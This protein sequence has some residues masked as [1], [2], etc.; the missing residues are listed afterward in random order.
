MTVPDWMGSR[1]FDILARAPAGATKD[2]VPQ[3]WQSLLADRFQLAVHREPKTV[4]HY[5]LTV[6]KG[7]PKFTE[8]VEQPV[9]PQGDTGG[10]KVDKDGF[11]ELNRPGMIGAADGRISLYRPNATMDL[12]ARLLAGQLGSPVTDETGLKGSYDIRLHWVR[13]TAPENMGPRLAEAVPQQLGL[14]L[15]WKK[16]PVE[17]LVV[18][19]IEKMPSGN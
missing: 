8:S 18:D 1:N 9:P 3:M 4:A 6:A 17:F 13:E 19:H 2:Q 14:R 16:G 15:E 12:L 10:S 5:S 11:P 7:G